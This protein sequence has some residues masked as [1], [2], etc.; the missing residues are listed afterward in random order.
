MKRIPVF[1]AR[2]PLGLVAL[3]LVV[4]GG[5]SA[6]AAVRLTKNS[7]KSKHIQ[8]GAVKRVDLAN[9]TVTAKKVRDGAVTVT[10]IRDGAVTVTKIGTG[11]VTGAKVADG[12][13][14]GTKVADGTIGAAD[15]DPGTVADVRSA[16]GTL[17]NTGT[18]TAILSVAGFGRVNALCSPPSTMGFSYELDSPITQHVHEFAHDPT[19]N[20]PQAQNNITGTTGATIGYSA[21]N[22][23]LLDGQLWSYTTD[24]VLWIELR[25]STSC[26]YR[27][28]ATV[29][30]NE[31][32]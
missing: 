7:V 28:R 2:Q 20:A 21:P 25:V 1:L 5:S 22:H 31:A 18:S 9:R 26:N 27:V 15:L 17:P 6:Y 10:K 24:R 13:I 23:A 14:T 12:A 16:A 32:P 29:D 30:A 4:L 19:D 3:I 11:Q 8:N